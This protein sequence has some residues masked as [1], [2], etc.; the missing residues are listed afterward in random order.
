MKV[1]TG[2]RFVERDYEQGNGLMRNMR[3]LQQ[4]VA[5]VLD[6]KIAYSADIIAEASK[7]RDRS[8]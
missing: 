4:Q 6:P 1:I 3:I 7:V 5:W 2:L 8:G